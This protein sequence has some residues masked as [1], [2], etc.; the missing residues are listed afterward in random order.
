MSTQELASSCGGTSA[1]TQAKQSTAAAVSRSCTCLRP[2]ATLGPTL[3]GWAPGYWPSMR[4]SEISQLDHPCLPSPMDQSL[5]NLKPD[6]S[7]EPHLSRR[8]TPRRASEQTLG[9]GREACSGRPAVA[10]ETTHNE[11]IA[12]EALLQALVA[13]PKNAH[14][15]QTS[16][17]NVRNFMWHTSNLGHTSKRGHTSKST[18]ADRQRNRSAT[19]TF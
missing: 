2:S 13:R 11:T 8:A 16:R 10:I 17:T 9:D 18:S 4:R 15:E 3:A 7:T 1:C 14:G 6:G 5:S 19:H 12:S